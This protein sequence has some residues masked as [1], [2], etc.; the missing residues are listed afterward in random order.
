MQAAMASGGGALEAQRVAALRTLGILDTE[1]EAEFDELAELA[2]A[3]CGVS[4]SL[5]TLLDERRQ[6]HKARVGM[7]DL[8]ELPRSVSFC[9]YTI[10]QDGVFLIEDATEDPRFEANPL[11]TGAPGVRFYAGAPLVTSDGMKVG[12]LCVLDIASR[13]LSGQ[14]TQALATL[15]KQAVTRIELRR[16]RRELEA[17][18]AELRSREDLFRTFADNIPFETYLK[19]ANG[20]LL[21]YNRKVAERFGISATEWLGK[22]SR[23]LWP[24]DVAA[25]LDEQEKRVLAGEM[26][27]EST[28]STPD[29]RGGETHWRR[30]QVPYR[31]EAGTMF[32]AGLALDET[33]YRLQRSQG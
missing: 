4:T 24:E 19:D 7:L 18:L 11:V 25:V 13:G 8:Q 23:D 10:Q 26:P 6:F 21:F 29:G 1:P 31:N 33:E 16:Q 14:Q 20:A 27:V 3:V 5:V 28:A 30:F 15:A 2:A 12:A 17:R 32:L 22:R 9:E